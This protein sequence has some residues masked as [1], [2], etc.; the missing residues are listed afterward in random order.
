MDVN[1]RPLVG[2]ACLLVTICRGHDVEADKLQ[3]EAAFQGKKQFFN[4][5]PKEG[6][7]GNVDY[8]EKHYF[9]LILRN[10]LTRGVVLIVF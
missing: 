3:F 7:I 6:S 1:W 5:F 4:Y 2:L 10:S 8:L 9:T